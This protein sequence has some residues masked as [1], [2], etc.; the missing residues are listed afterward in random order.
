MKHIFIDANIFLRI[1]SLTDDHPN[2]LEELIKKIETKKIK[3]YLTE[4]VIDEFYRNREAKL[5]A[6][7]KS[8]KDLEKK[9][10]STPS[11]CKNNK[12]IKAIEKRIKEINKF[13]KKVHPKL[14]KDS[15]NEK[16]T[17]DKSF[18]KLFKK[19][20]IIKIDG[21]I[22]TLAEERY[23][24]GNPPG[25]NNSYGDCINWLILLENVDNGKELILIT[26]DKDFISNLND[27][28]INSFLKKEWKKKKKSNIKLYKSLSRFFREEFK[29]KKITDDQILE[30][31]NYQNSISRPLKTLFLTPK[32]ID[33][34]PEFKSDSASLFGLDLTKTRAKSLF[35]GNNSEKEVRC[36]ECNKII[37]GKPYTIA[38]CPYCNSST[39]II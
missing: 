14:L 9:S 5:E 10:F 16:L 25:K 28:N 19:N 34:I 2:L 20:S 26:V 31:E 33:S 23:K 24:K 32:F 13:A 3:L 22:I 35:E 6:S 39:T 15:S 1:Y 38:K 29:T 36:V 8:I 27:D 37:Y 12:S 17:I 11:F 7:L 21:K 18:S 30:E 4:Q